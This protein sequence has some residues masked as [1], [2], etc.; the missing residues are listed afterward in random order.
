M[1]FSKE[2]I[3][4]TVL[5][6]YVKKYRAGKSDMAG[7][8][9]GIFTLGITDDPDGYF[10]QFIDVA[11]QDG[12]QS[13]DRFAQQESILIGFFYMNDDTN[14]GDEV[15]VVGA[16][17]LFGISSGG[18]MGSAQSFSSS[19]RFANK[20]YTSDADVDVSIEPTLYRLGDDST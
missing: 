20:K 17:Q 5:C 11:R 13:F 10:R 8:L 3:D 15:Y 14:I 6:D 18:E 16:F 4:V 9:N 1:E 7:T 19:F 2:E 12:S